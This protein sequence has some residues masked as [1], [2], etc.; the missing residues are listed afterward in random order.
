MKRKKERQAAG[1]EAPMV[2]TPAMLAR[3]VGQIAD[4][5]RGLAKKARRR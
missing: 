2:I 4:S 3:L 1:Q 5:V